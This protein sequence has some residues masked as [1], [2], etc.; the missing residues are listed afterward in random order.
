MAEK[1]NVT[2]ISDV[3]CPWCII[4]YKRLEAAI[5]E[6]GIQDKV[7][8]EW[9]PFE[10]NEDM[11][12]EGEDLHVHMARKYG[13]AQPD[14]I[15]ALATMKLLG[16]KVGFEFDFFDGIKMV[17]TRDAH[18]LLKYAKESGKQ[19]ELELCLFKAF[20]SE[21]KDVSDQQVLMQAVKDVGLDTEEALER[22]ADADAREHVQEREAYWRSKGVMSVPTMIFNQFASFNG[23]QTVE[24][25][26]K[27]LT[28]LIEE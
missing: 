15:S 21:Q 27:V 3:V 7:E 18:V 10:L 26:K 23:A 16:A 24:E 22:L 9:E 5:A 8:I 28:K 19:T 17:N 1:I 20:F 12:V 14:C 4:G 11:P 13:M 6:L 25:Y 2:I